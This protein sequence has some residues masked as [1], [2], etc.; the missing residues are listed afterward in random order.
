MVQPKEETNAVETGA[1]NSLGITVA[2]FTFTFALFLAGLYVMSLYPQGPIWFGVGMGMSMFAL[3]IA[4]DIV[5][6][7]F[8]K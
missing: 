4:F 7:F 6:R 1:S 8:N 5:P 2:I 3:F